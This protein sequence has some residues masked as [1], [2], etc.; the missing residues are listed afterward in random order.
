MIVCKIC[1]TEIYQDD[2]YVK[3]VNCLSYFHSDTKKSS[4]A[5]ITASEEKVII[6][7]STPKLLY[8]CSECTINNKVSNCLVAMMVKFNDAV[9]QLTNANDKLNK[10]TDY[11]KDIKEEQAKILFKLPAI[12]NRS[13]VLENKEVNPSINVNEVIEE[14]NLQKSKE[15]NVMIFNLHD[16][17]D[18]QKDLAYIKNFLTTNNIY[19]KD[20]KIKRLGSF[21]K[22]TKRPLKLFFN[23]KFEAFKL[24]RK[25]KEI[26]NKSKHKIVITNDKTIN[27]Q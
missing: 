1:K 5:E 11:V 22:D 12:E 7:K 23:S 19:I 17:S 10:F 15:K 4:C 3:C 16:H 14:I 25:S 24:L 21:N 18:F 27:K 8:R 6:L 2:T 20:L 9:L 13:S 26:S